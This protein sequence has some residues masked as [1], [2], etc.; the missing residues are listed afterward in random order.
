MKLPDRRQLLQRA[1]SESLTWTGVILVAANPRGCRAHLFGL[2]ES[3]IGP[4]AI[5]ADGRIV[6]TS[7][8]F[9]PRVAGH[10]PSPAESGPSGGAFS[11][12]RA[13]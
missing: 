13:S 3:E 9:Y 5:R 2:Q 8:R 1:R 12:S 7:H 10:N 4:T 6:P 11:A